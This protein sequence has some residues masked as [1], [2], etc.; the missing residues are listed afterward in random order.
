VPRGQ[1][2]LWALCRRSQTL[3]RDA[4]L[5]SRP[6]SGN[7][8]TSSAVG[9]QR[10]PGLAAGCPFCRQERTSSARHVS[11]EM[12]RYCSLIPGLGVKFSNDHPCRAHC[13]LSPSGSSDQSRRIL[14]QR[15]RER[16]WTYRGDPDHLEYYLAHS[17]PVLVLYDPRN[18]EAM[19][20]AR[21]QQ[22]RSTNRPRLGA[23]RT[24]GSA[25]GQTGQNS[26]D[27]KKP[28]SNLFSTTATTR[29][30]CEPPVASKPPCHAL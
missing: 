4:A 22:D 5:V 15:V 7:P 28:K 13:N 16:R 18:G 20:A 27:E 29:A 14:F 19:V 26:S 24:A 3:R 11:S 9:H 6:R 8:T 30:L 12:C 23:I 21:F 10:R 2:L 17:L 25:T 1:F